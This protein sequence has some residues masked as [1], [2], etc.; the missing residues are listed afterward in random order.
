MA[1]TCASCGTENPADARFCSDCGA[2]LHQTCPSCGAEQPASAAFCSSCGFALRQDARRAADAADER[3]ERRVV[4]VLFADLAGSTA[5]GELLDPEDFRELLGELFDLINTEVERFGGTTEKYAGDA[6]LAVFGNPQAHEDDPERAV[7][8]ALAVRDRFGSF[9]ER[10]EGR[11]GAKVGLRV[12]VNTG[13]VVAGRDAATRGELMV[14]GDAVNVAARLQQHAEPGEVLVGQRTQ[15][16]TARTIEY[17]RREDLQAKGKRE[18]LP[19]WTALTATRLPASTPRGFAGL[20]APLVGRREELAVLS[21]VAARVERERAPQLVTLFG[22]AGVGKSRLLDELVQRLDPAHVLIGRCLPYGEGI[23]YWPLAEVAKAHAGILDNDPAETALAKLRAAIESVVG[24]EHSDRALDAAAWTIGFSLPG[25][26]V[27]DSDPREAVRLLEEGWAR[28]VSALGRERVAI[29]AVEDVHWASSPLLDLIERLA[30]RLTDTHVLL[31]CT[32]RLELLETRPTWGAGKQNATTLTLTPLA[33]D[34]AAELVSSLLGEADVPEEVRDRVLALAEGNPFFLEEML[35]MLI[36]QGALERRNG[37]WASTERLADVTIPDSVHGVI[38][39]RIDLLDAGARDALLRCSVI[40]RSFWPVAVGVDEGVID[41]LRRTGLVSDSAG[42][43][44]GGMREFAF[45]HSLTRDVVYSTLPRPERRDLHRQVAEW[46]QEVARDRGVE[47][48]ELAAYHYG[49]ALRY[50]E[51][52]PAV[53]RRAVDSLLTAGDAAISRADLDAARA[54]LE[55]ALKFADDDARPT[56]HLVHSRL[57]YIEGNLEGVLKELELIEAQLGPEDAELRSEMLGWRSRTCWLTGRWEEAF[58]SANDAVA[59]LDGLPESPQLAR[60]LARRSQIE[61]LKHHDAAIGHAEEALAVARRVGDLFAE[62]NARINL[63]TEQATRG[64]GLDP[65]ELLDIVDRA[66]E[67]GVYDEAYRAIVNFLWSA[68]GFIPL[69]EAERV[70]AKARRQLG[71]V[72]SPS[73]IAA[74]VE[75]S[76]VY[77]L[78]YPAGRWH[79]V[80]EVISAIEPTIEFA[81]ARI[82][83]LQLAGGMAMRRGDLQAAGVW[84]EE[85]RSMALAT[86]EPQRIVPMAS[87]AVPWLVVAGRSE[88]LRSLVEEV[89]T[90]MEGRWPSV[91]TAVPMVR[92]LAAGREVTLLERTLDSM[93]R[94]PSQAHAAILRTSLIAGEGLLALEQGLADDAV[95]RLSAAIDQERKAGFVYDAACLELDLARALEA[96]GQIDAADEARKRAASVLEPLGVVNAF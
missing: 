89:S 20:T 44:M 53:T 13:D 63:F 92:A 23:T 85:L 37:A 6:V 34:A 82:V 1:L 27:T 62:V 72:S 70:S 57:E 77:M 81:I 59:A 26:P 68:P 17:R 49:E 65:D 29:V 36:D 76:K 69:D 79:E 90:V 91:Q 87:V 75:L 73:S 48:A 16:A 4:T 47:A 2:P 43:A 21:A 46:V 54:H 10:V 31:V 25:T 38:A 95:E 12:G 74:Y 55:R 42:S 61:M 22:P 66:I 60:A 39:A 96:A 28:Y 18:P 84:L 3:Q 56:A 30:E 19:A 8:T 64:V 93:R 83:W 32:A 51:D 33:P 11:H 78:S 40:G 80:D 88:E 41:S 45:K 9:A 24:D 5:L 94:T 58:S 7:R 67:A 71:G 15:A 86:G 52:D 50:G 14:S 35:N